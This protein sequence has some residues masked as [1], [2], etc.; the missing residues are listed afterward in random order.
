MCQFAI[1]LIGA[2][3]DGRNGNNSW[4]GPPRLVDLRLGVA[5]GAEDPIVEPGASGLLEEVRADIFPHDF[6]TLRHLEEAAVAA[7]ANQRIAIGESLRP[8][9]VRGEKNQARLNRGFAD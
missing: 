9:G 2:S 7:L 8:G 3:N 5:K 4:S 1:S 6:A